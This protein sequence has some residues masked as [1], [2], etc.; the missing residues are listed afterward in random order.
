MTE[1]AIIGAGIGGLTAALALV[2][3]GLAVDVYERAD[4]LAEVGAGVQMSPNATRVLFDLGLSERL[5][6]VAARPAGKQVRLWNT[7]QAW[8]LFDLGAQAEARFGA[9]YLMVHRADVHGCLI[10]ALAQ[11]AP[12]AL[13]LGRRLTALDPSDAGVGLTFADG[14]TARADI[15]VGADGVHSRVRAI[16][17]GDDDPVFTGC[18]A[19][20]GV[21]DADTLPDGVR[22]HLGTNWLGPGG[23]V[24]QYP[25]RRGRLIN[26]VGIVEREGFMTEGWTIPGTT[27][28]LAADFAGWHAD[29]QTMIG[30]IASPMKWALM[31]RRPLPRWSVR[32]VTLLGD[33]CHA[34]LPFLAQGAAM[35]IEDGLVL[36]RA[37]EAHPGDHDAA[38]AGYE[39]ARRDRT[40]RVIEGS[41]QNT[42]RFHNPVLGDPDR[43]ADYVAREWAGGQVSDRYDWLFGYDASRVAV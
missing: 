32:R 7:G 33:A 35:A 27:D 20:R 8:P 38:F 30:A 5:A 15:V 26:F 3:R 36:A 42:A 41:A 34:S 12:G 37:I 25:L 10:D 18:V 14:T 13:H 28:E 16:L 21:I 4:A 29:V 2:R 1:I 22:T 6:E 17:F 19:W 31:V 39:R 23:H 43:A 24:I 11:A 9:P 40:T